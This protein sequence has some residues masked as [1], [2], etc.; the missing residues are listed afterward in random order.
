[1]P[2]CVLLRLRQINL[3]TTKNNNGKIHG[4]AIA[5]LIVGQSGIRGIAPAAQLISI[6]AFYAKPHAKTAGRSSSFLLA[7][8][9]D[10]AVSHN[11]NVLNLSF[12]SAL[13]KILY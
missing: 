6:A 7:K 5:S 12:G 13:E 8:A 11:L 1:M 4:T 3:L 10:Q 9:F 2:V